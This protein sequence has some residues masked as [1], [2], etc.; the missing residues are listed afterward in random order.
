MS[1]NIFA[2]F[3]D[4]DELNQR[5]LIFEID[6]VFYGITLTSVLEIIQVQNIT[7]IPCVDNYVKGVVNLRGKVVPI[8]NLR[9]KF[10]IEEQEITDKTCII[11]I[12]INNINVGVLVDTVTEVAAIRDSDFSPPPKSNEFCNQY[13]SSVAEFNG[14]TILNINVAKCFADDLGKIVL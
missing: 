11:V 2:D 14:K 1:E 8:I 6:K 3:T 5:Y 4:E 10:Q 13:L 9:L 7:K 12:D